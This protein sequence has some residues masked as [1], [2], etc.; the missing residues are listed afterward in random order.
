MSCVQGRLVE[1]LLVNEPVEFTYFHQSW[2]INPK[3]VDWDWDGDHEIDQHMNF[4]VDDV[5]IHLWC[6]P[7]VY[8]VKTWG[9]YQYWPYVIAIE[10]IKITVVE[11]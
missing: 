1:H 2:F 10:P 3:T 9:N 11:Q 8:D 6:E 4:L 7:G 5:I